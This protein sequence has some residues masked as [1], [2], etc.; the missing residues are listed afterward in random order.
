M[1]IDKIRQK[2]PNC[3]LF[4]YNGDSI[5]NGIRRQIRDAEEF[6]IYQLQQI[7][8]T[9]VTYKKLMQK[10]GEVDLAFATTIRTGQD[11][12]R[13]GYR[14]YNDGT[15]IT[16]AEKERRNKDLAGLLRSAGYG[17]VTAKG[18]YDTVEVTYIVFNA[19]ESSSQFAEDMKAVASD[20]DQNSVLTWLK[21]ETHYL[22]YP[23]TNKKREASAAEVQEVTGNNYYTEFKDKKL[24]VPFPFGD[25]E[26]EDEQY[27]IDAKLHR[28]IRQGYEGA[29]VC[30]KRRELRNKW[31][32]EQGQMDNDSQAICTRDFASQIANQ[33]VGGD[34]PKSRSDHNSDIMSGAFGRKT[35]SRKKGI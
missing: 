15:E 33:R 6:F 10:L 3:D 25:T 30:S 32:A 13:G 29:W 17:W 16:R 34:K 5:D 24:S 18:N 27:L 4:I 26:E 23:K 14:K 22:Y 19:V 12:N 35:G 1:N 7:I 20:A 2:Y 9:G 11:K 31:A 28:P 21:G 8:S